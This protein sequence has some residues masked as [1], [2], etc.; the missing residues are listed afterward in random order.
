MHYAK[1]LYVWFLPSLLSAF[2][3]LAL[4]AAPVQAE[5]NW[6]VQGKPL[7]GLAPAITWKGDSEVYGFLVPALNFE[8]LFSKFTFTSGLLDNNGEGKVEFTFSGGKVNS[9]SPKLEALSC[10]VGDLKFSGPTNLFLHEGKTYNALSVKTITTYSG[11]GC[12]LTGTN[13]VTGWVVLEDK[14]N[15]SEEA[16]EHLIK[17]VPNGLFPTLTLKLG[18]QQVLVD[19]SWVMSL[20]GVHE[21]L[22]WSG[23]G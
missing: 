8:L 12:V 5:G 17:V 7:E 10:S 1:R 14:A 20:T 4:A 21:G 6:F 22:K 13:N 11:E 18:S 2:C 23:I 3:L 15:F 9:I 19:G 16:A